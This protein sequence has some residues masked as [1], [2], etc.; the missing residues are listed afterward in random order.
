MIHYISYTSHYLCGPSGP[1]HNAC[2]TSQEETDATNASICLTASDGRAVWAP[3]MGVSK[4]SGALT[5]TPKCSRALL[6]RTSKEWTP[7]LWKQP[8][9]PYDHINSKPA[10]YQPQSPFKGAPI[11]QKEPPGMPKWVRH[12]SYGS[13]I[14]VSTFFLGPSDGRGFGLLSR[15]L[16]LIY[17]RF[18]VRDYIMAAS[19]NLGFSFGGCLCNKSASTWGL[20]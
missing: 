4:T 10:L 13:Q 5:Y 15:G 12:S 8:Y 17:S 3:D 11:H 9:S 1:K 16:G 2:N 19:I 6:I 18:R 7:N 20:Y 14:A